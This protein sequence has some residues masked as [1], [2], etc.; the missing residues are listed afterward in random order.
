MIVCGED[1]IDFRPRRRGSPIPATS[2]YRSAPPCR[3][4][5]SRAVSRPA[6]GAAAELPPRLPLPRQRPAENPSELRPPDSYPGFAPVLSRQ[7]KKSPSFRMAISF[8][9]VAPKKISRLKLTNKLEFTFS[10]FSCTKCVCYISGTS[11]TESFPY[12]LHSMP[13]NSSAQF[14]N[15][16]FC[17]CKR[18][19]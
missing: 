1:S 2:G 3:F 6:N 19:H 13:R 12:A 10:I 14:R 17:I 8:W 9:L 18:P 15:R 11:S 5:H 4:C 7:R 16:N